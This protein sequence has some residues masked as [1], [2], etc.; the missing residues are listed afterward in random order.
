M[1]VAVAEG[2]PGAAIVDFAR[3][4][5]TDL[6]AVGWRGVIDPDRART[7][8]RVIRDAGCP[9]IV[10]RVSAAASR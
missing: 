1:H 5:A 4:H 6:I 3:E 9:V 10:F 2:E 8:R 7:M